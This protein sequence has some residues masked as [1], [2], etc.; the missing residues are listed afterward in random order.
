MLKQGKL[1][2]KTAFVLS[3]LATCRISNPWEVVKNADGLI[4]N[5]MRQ[6]FWQGL[7]ICF[8]RLSRSFWDTKVDKLCTR[9]T[10]L[11]EP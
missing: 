11:L 3:Y 5:L 8:D 9:P 6:K 4:P 10:G 1:L 2:S 7:A